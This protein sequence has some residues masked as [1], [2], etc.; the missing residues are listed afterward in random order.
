MPKR[1]TVTATGDSIIARRMP[2]YDDPAF[3]EMV[4]LLQSADVKFTNLEIVLSDYRGTPVVESGGMNLSAEPAVAADLMRMGFN[5]TAFANNHTL[6]YGE[7][8]CTRTL[9]ALAALGFVCA[10]AGRTLAEARLPAFLETPRGRIGLVACASTFSP[11]QRGGP[12]SPDTPGRPGLNPQRFDTLYVV[13]QE[14]MDAV[15]RIAERTGVER[16]RQHRIRMGFD[17]PRKREGEFVFADRSFLVGE[18]FGV[19]T[20]PH[21]G[22]LA[23]NMRAVRAAREMSDLTL[24]SI[25]AHEQGA[26]RWLPSD[27]ITTFA[28]AAIDAGA[29]MV[30][31][32]GPHLLRGLELYRGKP[33][34]YS[35]GNYIFQF[36]YLRRLAADDYESLRVDP[37]R[38]VP[39][40]FRELSKDG[41]QSFV[42]DRLYWEAVLPLCVFEDRRLVEIRLHPISL[43]FGT[44][45]P[46]RGTP[47]LA[48]GPAADEI[49][50]GFASLSR[51]FGTEVAINGQVGEVRLP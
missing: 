28:R 7:E 15:Q 2:A 25:H 45:W 26:E 32:H 40:V 31:G 18:E 17:H 23:A 11:G 35:L 14:H 4:R 19:R 37:S 27:F 49:L 24:V 48:T 1:I 16:Q 3:T 46:E 36:E 8:G 12:Q 38:T 13:D 5:L 29:D 47:R 41:T 39:E 6:N 9:D 51:P 50:A 44:S 22:D 33:I 42:A 21:E 34:F 30:I 20:V 43:G 10:G